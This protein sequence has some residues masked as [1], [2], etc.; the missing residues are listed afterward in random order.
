MTYLTDPIRELSSVFTKIFIALP[1]IFIRY[2]SSVRDKTISAKSD[3][4]PYIYRHTRTQECILNVPTPTYIPVG[5]LE[6]P[7]I[8]F[9]FDSSVTCT[10]V[11]TEQNIKNPKMWVESLSEKIRWY[12]S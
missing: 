5:F 2:L 11:R 6:R 1:F 9:N 3:E 7:D 8:T 12:N 4:I 10:G